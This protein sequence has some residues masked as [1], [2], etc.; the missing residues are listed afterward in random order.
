M[1]EY[2]LVRTI[3]EGRDFELQVRTALIDALHEI[4]VQADT[5]VFYD[6]VEDA[7]VMEVRVVRG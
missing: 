1:N 3:D 2:T 5:D 7:I 6:E 4:E